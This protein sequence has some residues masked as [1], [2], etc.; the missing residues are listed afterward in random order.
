[1]ARERK[2][3]FDDIPEFYEEVRPGYPDSFLAGVETYAELELRSSVLEVGAGTGKA[4]RYF[5]QR[6]YELTALELGPNL[7]SFLRSRFS[8]CRNVR[9]ENCAFEKWKN[10]D[11]CFDLFLC[12]QAF[13]FIDPAY[14]V[15]RA[16]SLLKKRG[17]IALI[18]TVD[19]SQ[20]TEFFRRAA[21]IHHKYLPGSGQEPETQKHVRVYGRALRDSA[22]FSEHDILELKWS[23]EYSAEDYVRLRST[24]SP[25]LVMPL[26]K[27]RCFHG[28]LEALINDLGGRI[29]RLHKTIALLARRAA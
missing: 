20:D 12:A 9:V 16:A 8:A 23:V 2:Y 26:E 5:A 24:F 4:T 27:R 13:H 21:P 18:W 6:N 7:C 15:S 25:D 3:A 10:G 22:A 19:C 14:G 17:A 28:E 1:M 11:S 29:V